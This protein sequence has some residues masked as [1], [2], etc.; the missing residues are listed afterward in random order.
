[1]PTKT[2]NKMEQPTNPLLPAQAAPAQPAPAA[3]A[4]PAQPAQPAEPGKLVPIDTKAQPA[5][6][7]ITSPSAPSFRPFSSTAAVQAAAAQRLENKKATKADRVADLKREHT[8]EI[9]ALRISL[10]DRPNA[11]VQKAVN[12]RETE[13]KKEIK[14]LQAAIK[15]EAEKHQKVR[16]P[17]RAKTLD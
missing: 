14:A 7:L 5:S 13:Q 1:V 17:V 11:E 16:K 2:Y 4:E 10:Q 9:K 12:A 15:A 6:D 8:A 3:A